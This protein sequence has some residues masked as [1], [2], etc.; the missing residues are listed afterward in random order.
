MHAAG[1]R[2]HGRASG[3]KSQADQVLSGDGERCL[4][5]GR[6]LHDAAPAMQRGGDVEIAARVESESLRA[7]QAAIEHL[8][9]AVGIDLI[10]GVE[11]R[12]RRPGDVEIAVVVEGQMVGRD[13]GLDAWRRR[14]SGGRVRS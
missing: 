1:G 4:A 11:A 9:V 12:S 6:D 13:A 8:D 7:P 2:Q 3:G 5:V 10:D 14:R